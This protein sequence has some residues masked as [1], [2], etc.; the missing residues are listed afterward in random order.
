[1]G[2]WQTGTT[3]S[4]FSASPGVTYY[5]FARAAT[6]SSGDNA[7][8]YSTYNTGWKALIPPQNVSATD[9]LYTN[10]VRITWNSVPGASYYRVYRA[11]SS[12][13][14]KT[15]LGSWQTGTTYY[16]TTVTPGTTYYYFVTAALDSS[17]YRQS[18]YS[19]YNTGYAN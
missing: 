7:S 18:F 14:T 19:T 8:P 5:Y 10:Q 16:D 17:G 12:T 13:G 15:A 4:D 1:M 9:G 3:Y 11:T 6:S 2:S